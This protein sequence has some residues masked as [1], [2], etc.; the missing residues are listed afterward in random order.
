MIIIIV[1]FVLLLFVVVLGKKQYHLTIN[2]ISAFFGLWFLALLLFYGCD[3]IDHNLNTASIIILSLGFIGYVLGLCIPSSHMVDTMRLKNKTDVQHSYVET[4]KIVTFGFYFSIILESLVLVFATSKVGFTSYLSNILKY[5]ENYFSPGGALNILYSLVLYLK[6]TMVVFSAFAII[7]LFSVKP[8]VFKSIT[9]LVL[10]V[11]MSLAYER[12]LTLYIIIV[13]LLTLYF[14]ISQHI[15]K[16]RKTKA[17]LI[18]FSF[19]GI[20]TIVMFFAFSQNLLNKTFALSGNLFGIKISDDFATFILYF[21]GTV[22]SSDIY[23][24]TISTSYPFVGTFRFI[25]ELFGVNTSAIF[26]QDF[27]NIPIE[28]NTAYY[29]YYLYL[30]GGIVWVFL[31]SI[32]FGL[33]SNFSYKKM[34]NN[35]SS[36][37]I[38]SVVL[39][40]LGLVMSTRSYMVLY[41]EYLIPIL[42]LIF[43]KVAFGETIFNTT[44]SSRGVC[45]NE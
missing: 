37:N 39:V 6:R 15:F 34:L 40:F 29:Q 16:K 30:E 45:I 19:V 14:C 28:Y 20:A 1:L 17:F 21:M 44:R 26:A 10:S 35:P 27:V 24:S 32:L 13:D 33:I 23:L 8:R 18:L 22:K 36:F 9:I 7:N 25:Y 41:L 43:I 31:A 4:T 3:F 2:P 12:P 11:A 42:T 38:V 5:H